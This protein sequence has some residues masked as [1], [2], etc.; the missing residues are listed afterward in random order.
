M[1]A[2]IKMK[3]IGGKTTFL[4]M[5]DNVIFCWVHVKLEIFIRHQSEDIRIYESNL[6]EMSGLEM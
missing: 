3:N 2:F 6:E 4:L 5:I 1:V